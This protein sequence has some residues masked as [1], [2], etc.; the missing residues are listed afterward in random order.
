[1]VATIEVTPTEVVLTS[2]GA[3]EQL[4]VRL[5]DAE[6]AG[7]QGAAVSWRSSAP[8]VASV[9]ERGL[10]T[11]IGDGS[12]TIT[13]TADAVRANVAVTVCA[14]GA[15]V[16]LAPGQAHVARPGC[17]LFVPSGSF[18]DRYRVAVVRLSTAEDGSTRSAT[19]QMRA[20]GVLPSPPVAL[21]AQAAPPAPFGEEAMALLARAAETARATAAAH[22]RV[23]EAE[24]RLL[25]T[26]GPLP[27]QPP[28]A[29]GE[30]GARQL[31]LS[32]PK[33]RFLTRSTS[34]T[35][36]SATQPTVTGLLIAESEHI[37]LYQDSAQAQTPSRVTQAQAAQVLDFYETH[38]RPVIESA[39][40]PVPDRDGNG[41]TLVLVTPAVTGKTAAF[42]WGGDLLDK[43]NCSAS[44]EMELIYFN[45]EMFRQMEEDD[46][47]ALET[48]VH[49][50]KHIVSFNQRLTNGTFTL[51]PGWMEEGG[52]EIAAEK[53]SRR[54]WAAAGGPSETAMVTAESFEGVITPE[55]TGVAIKLRNTRNYLSTQPHAL[56]YPRTDASSPYS[57]YGSGWHFLRFLGDA[58]GVA[59][60]APN[61]DASFFLQHTSSATPSGLPGLPALT[62]KTFEEL[63]V[64]YAAAVMLNG[65]GAPPV[66]RVFTTY[67]FTSATLAPF[68]DPVPGR[69]PYPVTGTPESPSV[70]FQT[71]VWSGPIGSAGLR[72]HDFVSNGT[73]AGVRI[74][75]DVGDEARVVV[76]RLR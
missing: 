7:V 27:P 52:A 60:S 48:L 50:V 49:E 54:A 14:S 57:I 32:P 59:A 75:V 30:S 38:G 69:Y 29:R 1:M 17:P 53:A 23:R 19:L 5:A 22:L 46:Y 70:P 58:H 55:N 41:H 45:V 33:L 43:A 56:V 28:R 24:A 61:A 47:Q 42:V 16:S 6:G 67:D 63:L 10:V 73:G 2:L 71:N 64:E 31:A 4:N 3:T 12:A 39:F 25:R 68:G 74:E 11:A 9:D 72:I 26:L 65:T 76:V 36:C 21:S 37:A 51:P 35:S 15:E 20:D 62:G 34:Q 8:A 44:N 18:G 13:V 40:G 66:E